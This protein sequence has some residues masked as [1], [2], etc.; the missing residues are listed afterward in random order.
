MHLDV[1]ALP[2]NIPSDSRGH[3]PVP[4]SSNLFEQ[5]QTDLYIKYEKI[6]VDSPIHR[7]VS[8]TV[9]QRNVC[10]SSTTDPPDMSDVA[11][12]HVAALIKPTVVI[13]CKNQRVSMLYQNYPAGMSRRHGTRK[14]KRLSPSRPC[15]SLVLITEPCQFNDTTGSISTGCDTIENTGRLCESQCELASNRR[16][17]GFEKPWLQRERRSLHGGIQPCW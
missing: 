1:V 16:L 10:R 14:L 9:P 6:L 7:Y 5:I 12:P 17:T 4:R 11:N 3:C 15:Q 8:L 2:V 13:R